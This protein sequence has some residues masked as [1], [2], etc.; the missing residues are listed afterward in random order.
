[1]G[2]GDRVRQRSSA[3][4]PRPGREARPRTG[5]ASRARPLPDALAGACPPDGRR[6]DARAIRH[7]ACRRRR[8]GDPRRARPDAEGAERARPAGVR[9]ECGPRA[10]HAAGVDRHGGRDAPDRSEG[11]SGGPRRLSRADRAR[12]GPSHPPHPG[13][14][15][16]GARRRGGGGPPPRAD[17]PR[18]PPRA[19]GGITPSAA[20]RG[21]PR[22][23]RI[24][25]DRAGAAA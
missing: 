2:A 13:A 6:P 19:G 18:A 10:A 11:R 21:H 5:A 15:R 3:R 1:M 4:G 12:V 8:H 16:A 7:S 22:R 23:L 25:L 14:A 9:N 24:K 17:P 20:E